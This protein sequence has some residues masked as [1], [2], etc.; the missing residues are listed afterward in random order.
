MNSQLFDLDK[1]DPNP[2]QTREREDLDHVCKIAESIASQGL[3]QVPMGRPAG[4]GR[5]QLAFGHTRL[6]AY[7][8]IVETGLGRMDLVEREEFR[9]MPVVV[10]D[11]DDATLFEMGVG[12][13]LARKDLNP[14]EE[15][16]AMKTYRDEF[17][18]T[19][20]QVGHL[21]GLSE[22]AVRNKIRLLELPEDAQESLSAGAIS[23]GTARS[24]LTLQ[25]ALKPDQMA[26]A[27]KDLAQAD[28]GRVQDRIE[29]A[30]RN[31]AVEMHKNWSHDE[32]AAG[33][34]L[35]KLDYELDVELPFPT[36]GQ[37][38]KA[39]SG[40]ESF[41]ATIYLG[42]TK[43][44]N[45]KETW[46]LKRVFEK[47]QVQWNA[48]YMRR[49]L[50]EWGAEAVLE[51]L[52]FLV[53][54]P[55]CSKCPNHIK[56]NGAHYCGLRTCWERRRQAFA[57]S[58]LV[59][60]CD[61]TG[62]D[63]YD[64]DEDG[65][66]FLQEP[67]W[68]YDNRELGDWFRKAYQEKSRDVRL[69]VKIAASAH[70]ITKSNVVQLIAI[71][72]RAQKSAAIAEESKAADRA[73]R[74]AEQ[75]A[76]EREQQRQARVDRWVREV[77]VPEFMKVFVKSLNG[78]LLNALV[79]HCV[80]AW[81][82]SRY[83]PPEDLKPIARDAWIL[84]MYLVLAAVREMRMTRPHLTAIADHLQGVATTWGVRLPENWME[85]AKEMEDGE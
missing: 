21:F 11:L 58:E 33:N 2:Y 41:E 19:S 7:R 82:R 51:T 48:D 49:H 6:A 65:K 53:N 20:L 75:V 78:G 72:D 26:E 35:W 63:P 42:L 52:D 44:T 57:E 60:L 80:S 54:P 84:A 4:F 79:T 83:N 81:E 68:Y 70:G 34:G 40:P 77:A 43:V 16:R 8:L 50:V 59:R 85:T 28:P 66:A 47:A 61:E 67:E 37:F 32:P 15:A 55:A 71:G 5:V 39:Y 29:S 23:E 38:Q 62:I 18:K 13:N 9:Q 56:Q 45:A 36:W 76:L 31:G 64:P 46:S 3:M 10:Q 69:R 1:I 30:L 22:S 17:K 27:V 74:N 25:K 24:L 14:L 12:E 73:Q